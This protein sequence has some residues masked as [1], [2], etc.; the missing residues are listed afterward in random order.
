MSVVNNPGRTCESIRSAYLRE[1]LARVAP[2]IMTTLDIDRIAEAILA[3]DDQI[4]PRRKLDLLIDHI[5]RGTAIEIT[6]TC[7]CN[8]KETVVLSGWEIVQG[9]KLTSLEHEPCSDCQRQEAQPKPTDDN[10][11][12]GSEMVPGS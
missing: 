5:G 4:I 7:S 2:E 11:P 10:A 12:N 8:H 3:N 6:I 9:T 1:L